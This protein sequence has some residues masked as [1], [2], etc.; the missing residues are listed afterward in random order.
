[1]KK[2]DVFYDLLTPQGEQL[3]Q[4][5]W[6]SYPRPQFRREGWLNLNGHWDF[7]VS[8]SSEQPDSYDRQILVPFAPETLL[9]GLK[10]SDL[11]GKYLF[12]RTT[13]S[14]PEEA[15]GKRILLHFGAVDQYATVWING[16]LVGEHEGGYQHFTFDITDH[17][18]KENTLI[19]QAVDH[20]SSH[21]LPYGKQRRDRGGMWY[22]PTT[23]IWQTVWLEWVPEHHIRTFYAKPGKGYVDYFSDPDISGTLTLYDGVCALEVYLKNGHIRIP[24]VRPRYWCP[25]DPFLYR[26]VLKTDEDQVESYFAIREL[27]VREV[28]GVQRL[29]L[30]GKPYFF[31][32]ILDQG[33]WSDGGLTP[34]D[35]SCYEWDIA[36]MQSLGFN[37]LRKHIKVEPDEFYYA[38]DRLGMIVF[39]DMVNNGDYNYLRDTVLPTF[40]LGKKRSD[41]K[42]QKDPW[43]KEL[44]LRS[45]EQTVEQLQ[46]H[47]CI[48]CWTI[49]NEGWGQ[50]DASGA[51]RRLKE[52]DDSRFIDTA[53]G[54]YSGCESDVVSEHIYFR[55]FRAGKTDKPLFLSEF[56]GYSYPVEGHCFHPAKAYGYRSYTDA[57]GYTRG[58]VELFE[59]EVIANIPE[60]LCASVYTQVSDVEDEING[61]VTFDRKVVKVEPDVMRALAARMVIPGEAEL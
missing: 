24:M 36:T 45:M 30:N 56:G 22:T 38:C 3:G 2:Q 13:F 55:P 31:H 44:F 26:M 21:R 28:D 48:C 18:V 53:S 34:A 35:P 61:L 37:M 57:E 20:M 14:V 17:L 16:T 4:T 43:V 51:Y 60:G 29:C 46:Y 7:A 10:L 47:P 58:L 25:E 39:Q 59:R 52:L 15:A 41:A 9:S 19:V 54:W 40:N 49:Y 27:S 33:Y 50:V 23:G 6:Q 5:P 8:D 32:G 12:Y 11:E 42:L 1:M